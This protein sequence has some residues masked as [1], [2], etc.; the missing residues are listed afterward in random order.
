MS[1]LRPTSFQNNCSYQASAQKQKVGPNFVKRIN[2]P[3]TCTIGWHPKKR[4][5]SLSTLIGDKSCTPSWKHSID[6]FPLKLRLQLLL[7]DLISNVHG[8]RG[9]KEHNEGN[10][11]QGLN[12]GTYWNWAFE[13]SGSLS[14]WWL[15]GVL[16]VITHPAPQLSFAITSPDNHLP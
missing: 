4:S 10:Y 12:I 5:F 8:W 6:Y 2:L 9:D 14:Y 3:S 13:G 15:L 1:S 11:G 7:W 16:L